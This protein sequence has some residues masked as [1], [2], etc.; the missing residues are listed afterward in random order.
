MPGSSQRGL[1]IVGVLAPGFKLFFP[2]GAMTP[3]AA[4]DFWVANNIGYDTAHRNLLTVGAI[5]RL[6]GG[7]TLRQ[8][9][10]RL[11]ALGPELRKR[12]FDPAAARREGELAVRAAL[13]GS[14]WRLASQMLAEAL[15]LSGLGT[16]LGVVFAWLGIHVLA[17]I[18]PATLPRIESTAIDWHVLAFAAAAGLAAVAVFGV[19]PAAGAAR[20]DVNQVLRGGRTPGLGPGHLLRST[21]VVAEVALSFVLLIGS[22]LMFRSF[23]ELRRVDPGYDPRGLLTFFVTRDWQLTR[24][25]GDRKSTRL[26]S[27]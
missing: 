6:R 18:A 5:G 10:D 7:I 12:S 15:L 23:L 14:W 21:V 9:Q 3:D 20:P 26:N 16:V 8:A 13:G 17:G 27:S 22:G 19:I 25:Q 1:R 24:Q 11:H 4:P 2:P